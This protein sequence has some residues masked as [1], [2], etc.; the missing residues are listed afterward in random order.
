MRVVYRCSFS[1]D[2]DSTQIREKSLLVKVFAF[3]D[4]LWEGMMKNRA[5]LARL[6]SS[7]FLQAARGAFFRSLSPQQQKK[8][9]RTI[10][11]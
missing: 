4:S 5:L 2:R 11:P 7:P 8:S 3:D 1:C 10:D 9:H 6:F